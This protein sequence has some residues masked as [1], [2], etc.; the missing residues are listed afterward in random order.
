MTAPDQLYPLSTQDGKAIP[1]DVARPLGLFPVAF[2]D[3]VVS[4]FTLPDEYNIVSVYATAACILRIGSTIA[5]VANETEIADAIYIAA[6]THYDIIITSGACAVWGLGA[7][8][9]Y[10]TSLQQWGALLQSNQ[11]QVG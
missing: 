4:D 7:G 1:L 10:I 9:I 2:T 6:D 3:G 5:A 8:T 11:T